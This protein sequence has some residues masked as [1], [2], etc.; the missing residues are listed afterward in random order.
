M[1]TKKFNKKLSLSKHTISNLNQGEM[2]GVNGGKSIGATACYLTSPS[3]AIVVT[4]TTFINLSDACIL[5]RPS[6]RRSCH[7]WC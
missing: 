1:K 3:E 6:M 2:N 4:S 7:G 5:N